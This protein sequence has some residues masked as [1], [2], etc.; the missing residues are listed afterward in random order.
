MVRVGT[1][2]RGIDLGV[3]LLEMSCFCEKCLYKT[4]PGKVRFGLRFVDPLADGCLVS[5]LEQSW[6]VQA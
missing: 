1:S 6:L 3:D 2:I 4:D 5:S